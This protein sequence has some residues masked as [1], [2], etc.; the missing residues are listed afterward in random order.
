MAPVNFADTTDQIGVSWLRKWS[1]FYDFVTVAKIFD[2]PPPMVVRDNDEDVNNTNVYDEELL[3]VQRSEIY[4]ITS[5]PTTLPI[6]DV[7]QWVAMHVDF[8]A[9]AVVADDGKVLGLLTSNNF[10]NMYHLKPTKV[11]CNKEYLDNFYVAHLKP[12]EVMKTSY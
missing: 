7:M 12:H 1:K 2:K 8:R 5:R 10:D 9:M 3:K 6:M 4:K 11:K